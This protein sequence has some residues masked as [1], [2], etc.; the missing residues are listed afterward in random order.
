MKF[1]GR[2][3]G[4]LLKGAPG[5][6]KHGETYMQPYH[7]S[8]FA[9]W[10]LLEE[11]PVLVVPEADDLDDVFEEN[12]FVPDEEG[13]EIGVDVKIE[14]DDDEDVN[15]DP[16]VGATI[17]PYMSM[18]KGRLVPYVENV[19]T[20]DTSMDDMTISTSNGFPDFELKVEDMSRENLLDILKDAD[21][22]VKPRT[23]TT[24]LRKMVEELGSKKES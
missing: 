14:P 8:R 5:N 20:S 13:A 24:T 16:N 7:M 4:R 21:V 19:S 22:E 6:Y 10:E 15:I 9:F 17:E 12:V 3:N 11:D 23:R 18:R 1:V 2:P